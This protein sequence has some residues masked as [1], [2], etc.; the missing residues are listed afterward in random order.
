M[1]KKFRIHFSEIRVG[2]IYKH[3][4][5][6]EEKA[7]ELE[8]EIAWEVINP[9]NYVAWTDNLDGRKQWNGSNYFSDK[10]KVLPEEKKKSAESLLSGFRPG[11]KPGEYCPDCG[12]LCGNSNHTRRW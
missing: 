11:F 6:G 7:L 9:D 8:D 4:P 5:S 2:E 10:D 12:G 1:E 3:L